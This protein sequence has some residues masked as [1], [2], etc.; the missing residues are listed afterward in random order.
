MFLVT[1]ENM[2]LCLCMPYFSAAF[3]NVSFSLQKSA[4]EFALLSAGANFRIIFLCEFWNLISHLFELKST[5]DNET[6][7]NK[8]KGGKVFWGLSNFCQF[9]HSIKHI[10]LKKNDSL[11]THT[12]TQTQSPLFLFLYLSWILPKPSLL[13]LFNY[14]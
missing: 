7:L 2:G 1:N 4:S 8:Q 13:I 10:L 14:R 5:K 11:V 6:Y 3:S 9:I 12:H